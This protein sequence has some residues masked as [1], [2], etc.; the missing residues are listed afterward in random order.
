[1]NG[2]RVAVTGL[3]VICALGRNLSETWDSLAAGRSGIG[4]IEGVDS[5]RLRFR[6]AA[7]VRGFDPKDSFDSGRAGLLDRFSQFALI[8]AREAVS[9]AARPARTPDSW[10]CTWPGAT[11]FIR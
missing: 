5:S 4:P 10:I 11:A 9:W 7:E 1:M 2:T 6:N 8:A 3:G